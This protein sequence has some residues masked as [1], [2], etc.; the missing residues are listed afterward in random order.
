MIVEESVDPEGDPIAYQFQWFVN[1]ES[2]PDGDTPVIPAFVT[3]RDEYWEVVVT[4]RDPFTNSGPASD[5]ISI[6]N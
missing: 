5:D 4:A 1:D 6:G 2:Y 3:Q